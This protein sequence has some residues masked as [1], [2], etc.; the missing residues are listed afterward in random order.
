MVEGA[1]SVSDAVKKLAQDE[2]AF[3]RPL[4]VDWNQGKAGMYKL[5]RYD[6]HMLT[7][8]AVVGLDESAILKM[9]KEQPKE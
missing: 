5:V 4:V 7:L 6:R 3:K 1:T 2:N 9:I 8:G